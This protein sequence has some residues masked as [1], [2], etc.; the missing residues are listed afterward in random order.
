MSGVSGIESGQNIQT[1]ARRLRSYLRH[2]HIGMRAFLALTGRPADLV[3]TNLSV[4]SG[5]DESLSDSG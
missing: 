2:L 1:P 4:G 5:T 3:D